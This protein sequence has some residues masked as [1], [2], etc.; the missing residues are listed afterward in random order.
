MT[1]VSAPH[2]DGS[3]DRSREGA[4]IHDDYRS[5]ASLSAIGQMP[6]YPPGYT[7]QYPPHSDDAMSRMIPSNNQYALAA[8]YL[9]V[10]SLI[11]GIGMLLVSRRFSTDS[12]L[13]YYKQYP[14]VHG[15]HIHGWGS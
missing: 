9:A 10:F 12:G 14:Q 15:E 11:P 6:Y 2:V 4:S 7:R 13:K 1:D 8:Y 3:S 5:A